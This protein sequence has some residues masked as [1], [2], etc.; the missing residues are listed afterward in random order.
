MTF[1]EA[2]QLIAIW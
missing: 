2:V 1:H